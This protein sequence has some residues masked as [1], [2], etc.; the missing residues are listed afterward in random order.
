MKQAYL[1]AVQRGLEDAPPEDRERLLKRLTEAISAYLEE[2]PDATEADIIKAFGTPEACAAEL[3][4]ECDPTKVA[5]VR[6]KRKMRLYVAIA[7]LAVLAAAVAAALLLRGGSEIPLADA[8]SH[9]GHSGHG[10]GHH[11]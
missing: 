5:A 11:G 4:E 6:R 7:A 10:F 8:F 9:G 2:D 3:L 1:R